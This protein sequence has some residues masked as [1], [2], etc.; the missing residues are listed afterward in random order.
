MIKR[1]VNWFKE[2][3]RAK[4]LGFGALVGLGADDWYCAAYVGA[5]VSGAMEFKDRQWGGKWDWID[6]GLTYAGVL[7]GYCLRWL[8]LG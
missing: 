4:H 3:N 1:I 6:F 5:G 7:A 2:S 8:L